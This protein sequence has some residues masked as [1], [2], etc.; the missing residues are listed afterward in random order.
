MAAFGFILSLMQNRSLNICQGNF[1]MVVFKY[2]ILCLT[3][4]GQLVNFTSVFKLC[5]NGQPFL[6]ASGM[7]LI[8]K[9]RYILKLIRKCFTSSLKHQ[10]TPQLPYPNVRKCVTRCLQFE[11]LYIPTKLL[12]P[13]V[14][15]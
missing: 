11:Q 14:M 7:P 2:C 1:F 10:L 5:F 12:K 6:M 3:L 9:C 13:V 4:H 8:F 15:C